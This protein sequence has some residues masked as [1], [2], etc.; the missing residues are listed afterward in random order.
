MAAETL[1][2]AIRETFGLGC[3]DIAR[4]LEDVLSRFDPQSAAGIR[5]E[6]C[7]GQV[8]RDGSI[9]KLSNR[10]L[11]L[12]LA[13]AVHRRPV[14]GETLGELLYP[15]L[16]AGAAAN[17]LKVYLHR[18]REKMAQP[19][20]SCARDGYHLCESV[21]VDLWEIESTVHALEQRAFLLEADR[22]TLLTTIDRLHSR[23]NAP[24][25]RWEWFD[26]TEQIM[27][28][29]ATK[30]ANILSEEAFERNATAELLDLAT[31]ITKYDPCDE[32]AREIAIRAHLGAG[33]RHE[34]VA[35]YKHYEAVLARDLNA[36]PS[37]YLRSLVQIA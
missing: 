21:S 2:R 6:L 11:E 1:R 37:A 26:A 15:D 35:E 19:F 4:S 13:L 9:V 31:R 18:V 27:A 22:K 3:T 32:R 29:L 33:R 5:V 25:W 23:R 7:T 36:M 24:V 30:A 17:R 10:E 20:I 28:A 16:E 34:A 12:C 14:P 8:L